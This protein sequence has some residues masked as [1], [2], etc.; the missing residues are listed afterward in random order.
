MNDQESTTKT[1]GTSKIKYMTDANGQTI[2]VK[3]VSAYDR[4]RDA[5]AKRILLRFQKARR[6]L[7]AVVADSL[8]DLDGIKAQKAAL[9]EKGNFSATSFDGSIKVE[10]R[11]QYT[12]YLDERV[13]AAR[14]KMLDYAGRIAGRIAG[15]DGAAIRQIIE[16]A[17]AANRQGIL[18]Y[19][20]ILALLRLEI[21]APEWLEAKK[22]LVASIK[23]E[24]G[25]A[26]LA[27][28]LRP[29]RQHDYE[30]VRLDLADCW[31]KTTKN[32]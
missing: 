10:I 12:I 4:K 17:F 26:Y 16:A 1:T 18:P 6:Q 23:P 20:K 32:N 14:E 8:A 2:P 24:R 13:A 30:P 27:C 3:Y 31:P 28:Y 5:A 11:Q 21:T 9:G 7:E 25:K 22:L 29:D 15:N 19:T